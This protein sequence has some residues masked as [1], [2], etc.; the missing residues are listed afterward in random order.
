MIYI[1]VSNTLF[2]REDRSTT[3]WTLEC[4]AQADAER[5]PHSKW[6]PWEGTQDEFDAATGC[7]VPPHYIP[8]HLRNDGRKHRPTRP[9]EESSMPFEHR[10]TKKAVR[11]YMA[12]RNYVLCGHS[13][14]VM[15][16]ERRDTSH[17]LSQW[18]WSV[19][20]KCWERIW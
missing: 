11:A 5:D 14:T 12:Q 15:E 16:F 2:L 9:R 17:R 4:I 19:T 13:R 10:R 18:W 8:W 7:Q 20:N 3:P 6:Q 1:D